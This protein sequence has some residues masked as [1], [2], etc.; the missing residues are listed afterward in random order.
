MKKCSFLLLLSFN[1][2]LTSAQTSTPVVSELYD[3]MI[4]LKAD[5]GSLSRFYTVVYAPQRSQRFIDFFEQKQ[6][7]LQGFDFDALSVNGQV[8]YTMTQQYINDKQYQYVAQLQQYN[9]LVEW[10]DAADV[11]YELE[12]KRRRGHLMQGQLIAE[13]LTVVAHNIQE[14]STRLI[15]EDVRFVRD[16]AIRAK[17]ILLGQQKA[18]RSVYSFYENYDPNFTWW[19]EKPYL[20]VDDLLGQYASLIRNQVDSASM[21][22][23]DGSGIIGR[24]IGKKELLR[25]LKKEMIP[26]GPDELVAI[27]NKEFAWCDSLLLIA[28][29]KMGFGTDW[30]AAQEQVKQSFVPP[31]QQ[32][33]MMLQ[34]YKTSVEFLKDKE[35]ISI[36]PLAE[37]TWRMS[38][39]S[40]ER[41]LI[42]PFFLGGELLQISY[43]TK[44]MN[45]E[46]K[47]MSMRGN[48]PH[49]AKAV[50]HH[51][52]I[53][54]HHL[55]FYMNE[56]NK[57]YR[58][59]Y[60]PF[61]TEGWALYWEMLLWDK[62]F[63]EGPEDEIGMLFWRM[64]RCA[65][66]IFS[67]N[68]HLGKW[69][70]QQCIDFLVDRVG[71]ERANAEGEVRRS[72][73]GGYGPLYQIAY[74]VGGLQFRALHQQLVV[75]GKWT[76]MDF[77]DAVLKENAM[78]VEML[79]AILT[80]QKLEE[81]F[82]TKW[83]FYKY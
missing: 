27:A 37:E 22:A 30:R 69:T 48:N 58:N 53:A 74:M 31:G 60:T 57:S 63:A 6:Q 8:D 52:L 24:P 59:F 1:V 77:H 3:F 12:A 11:I 75:E 62:G 66:I 26:Y 46:D 40:P 34:L 15:Q 64:H 9:S 5:F 17:R 35:L 28:S 67:L 20:L 4:Q 43:P 41:Q 49:F 14:V 76:D 81:K 79:R 78:P 56:R 82:E 80:Q 23:D 70:P 18:L 38:M 44:D 47:M 73:T 7:R 2:L 16:E 45:H 61:W 25:Q 29:A 32:P 33:Q 13:K 55:Q 19:V 72:F 42:S 21:H 50:I 71:H 65:R 83:R 51:E 39:I 36:P 68:Y 10:V 54:G